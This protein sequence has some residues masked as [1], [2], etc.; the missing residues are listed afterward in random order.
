[1]KNIASGNN[2]TRNRLLLAALGAAI[3]GGAGVCATGNA[4]ES[5]NEDPSYNNWITPTMGGLIINGSKAQFQQANPTTGPVN[6]GIQDMHYQLDLSNNTILKI[7]GHALFDNNDYK[8]QIELNKQDLGYFK[9]GYTGYSTYYNGNGGYIPGTSTFNQ[10]GLG[11]VTSTGSANRTLPNGLMVNP[12]NEYSLYRSSLWAELGLRKEGLPEI[13]FR[14]EHNIRNGQEDSTSWGSAFLNQT[15]DASTVVSRKIAP[16]FW[17]INETRDIFNLNAKQL[18]GK[19]DAYGNTEVNANLHYELN[20]QDDQLNYSNLLG[21]TNLAN[22]SARSY[23]NTQTQQLSLDNYS[24]NISTITRF[25][26]KLWV[27]TGYSYSASTSDLGGSDVSGPSPQGPFI[28]KGPGNAIYSATGSA[29]APGYLNLGGGSRVG[30]NIAMLNLMW[31]PFDGLT[32]TPSGRYELNDTA[33]SASYVGTTTKSPGYNSLPSYAYSGVFLNDFAQALEIKYTKLKNWV[34]YGSVN[35]DQQFENRNYWSPANSATSFSPGVLNLNANNSYITQKLMG[36]ANWYP[37]A[38]LSAGA[39]FYWQNQNI[40]QNVAADDPIKGNQR[41]LNQQWNTQDANFRLSW[42]PFATVSLVSKYDLQRSVINSQWAGDPLSGQY[43]APSGP[44]ST[45]NAQ[46]ITESA[47]WTP[48]DRL[49]LQ[50]NLAYILSQLSSPNFNSP[51]VTAASNNYWTAGLGAGYQIDN[52]T[53]FRTDFTYYFANNYQNIAASGVPYG[54]GAT[55][56]TVSASLKRQ[57]TRNLSWSLKYYFDTYQD[58][59]SGGYNSYV[60][61]VIATSLQM[62]F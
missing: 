9:V 32:I 11:S 16:S 43:V 17:N 50:G 42:T 55:Q 12:G 52:R 46:S 1:M 54:A 24:G 28:Y 39:Q 19:P 2:R 35:L 14:Y 29:S 4:A 6:G 23:W 5:Q 31:M 58:Q 18:I 44:S 20:R 38:N 61:Q 60:A 36:G 45:Y 27:T 37:L 34:I 15:S 48:A 26:E 53:E 7:D 13:T 25:G 56:Y 57:I 49:F 22:T 33:S 40:S 30:Q 62:Q 8:A 21:G 10:T 47:T 51:G 59:L 41:L 3:L